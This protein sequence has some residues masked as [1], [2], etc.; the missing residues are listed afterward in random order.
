MPPTYATAT[1]ACCQVSREEG[2]RRRR[3][4]RGAVRLLRGRGL[5]R[6]GPAGAVGPPGRRPGAGQ[7]RVGAQGQ[8]RPGQ[9]EGRAGGGRGGGGRG[10]QG[11]G[12]EGA[13]RAQGAV[14]DVGTY[15]DAQ[16]N[17]L[18]HA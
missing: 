10:G 1:P 18:V 6:G 13:V 2:G 9:Q 15:L 3:R 11:H 16:V 17:I 4:R 12:E 5:P 14:A 8:A 7:P